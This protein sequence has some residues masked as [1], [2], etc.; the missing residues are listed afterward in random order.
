MSC[1]EQA[2]TDMPESCPKWPCSK[3]PD[4]SK[5]KMNSKGFMVCPMCGG[6]YGKMCS[7]NFSDAWRCAKDQNLRQLSCWCKCHEYVWV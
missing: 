4:K 1:E 5:L 7:C 2:I 6:S 3:T